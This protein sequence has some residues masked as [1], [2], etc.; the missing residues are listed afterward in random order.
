MTLTDLQVFAVIFFSALFLASLFESGFNLRLPFLSSMKLTGCAC[1]VAC[2]VYIFIETGTHVIELCKFLH[3]RGVNQSVK[4]PMLLELCPLI[5]FVILVSITA[6]NF[7]RQDRVL[8][9]NHFGP[10]I[11]SATTGFGAFAFTNKML[12]ILSTLYEND[13][14]TP[15]FITCSTI[16]IGLSLFYGAHVSLI[17]L[18]ETPTGVGIPLSVCIATVVLLFLLRVQDA[19]Q[20]CRQEMEP[21]EEAARQFF[22]SLVSWLSMALV[23]GFLGALY[24]VE[25]IIHSPSS[26]VSW[27]GPPVLDK[28]SIGTRRTANV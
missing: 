2:I 6:Y 7:T 8:E 16:G 9:Y 14:A 27:V 23:V 12:L 3:Q 5:P 13:V 26:F 17:A 18:S 10:C 25:S 20:G 15:L 24:T 19:A 22:V 1:N 11:L 21:M 4:Y 28:R